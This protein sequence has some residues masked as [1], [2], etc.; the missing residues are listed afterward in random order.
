MQFAGW[1]S[2]AV[3]TFGGVVAFVDSASDSKGDFRVIVRPDPDFPE[4]PQPVFLRQGTRTKAWILLERVTMGYELWRRFNGF[5][6]RIDI[7]KK[8]SSKDPG[9]KAGKGH[10]K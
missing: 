9:S 10:T 3:G 2:V 8:G 6:P 7:E 4:W 1:P 5:P